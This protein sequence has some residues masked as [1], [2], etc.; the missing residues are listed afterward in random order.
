MIFYTLLIYT[1]GISSKDSF[2]VY[3]IMGKGLKK[4]MDRLRAEIKRQGLIVVRKRKYDF[5]MK[6]DDKTNQVLL[7][8]TPSSQRT[9]QN[10]IAELK[11]RLDFQWPP[12]GKKPSGRERR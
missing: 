2:R 5:A 8:R 1:I 12:P 3:A 9:I 11:R 7:P 4:D 10:K 6:R